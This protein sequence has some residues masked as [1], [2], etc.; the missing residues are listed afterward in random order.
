[1][2]VLHSAPHMEASRAL[3]PARSSVRSV[4]TRIANRKASVRVSA[5]A[6]PEKPVTEYQ[7]PDKFGRY[8]K[9]GG[10]YVPETLIPALEQLEIDYKEAIADPAFKASGG[11][12]HGG[13]LT[14]I[15]PI[16]YNYTTYTRP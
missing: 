13:R 3:G 8:G 14:S 16:T 12:W 2:N 5:V 4:V 7:R 1:M 10:K 9:F 15:Q 11:L 6:A